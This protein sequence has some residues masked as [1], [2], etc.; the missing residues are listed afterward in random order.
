M[1]HFCVSCFLTP[2][3][4]VSKP[5]C[6][7]GMGAKNEGSALTPGFSVRAGQGACFW[8]A[9]GPVAAL[10]NAHVRPVSACS[11]Q[12]LVVDHPCV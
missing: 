3:G 8:E 12:E 11:W 9:V 2:S 6:E 4:R 5:S 10:V 7:S 1:A